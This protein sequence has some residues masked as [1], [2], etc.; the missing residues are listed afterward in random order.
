ML[1][2][3]ISDSVTMER[4]REG[5]NEIRKCGSKTVSARQKERR[6]MCV[7]RDKTNQKASEYVETLV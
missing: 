1:R 2:L 4:L 7:S 3:I 5:I 6:G